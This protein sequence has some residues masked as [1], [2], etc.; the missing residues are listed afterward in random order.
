MAG[1]ARYSIGIL[2]LREHEQPDRDHQQHHQRDEVVRQGPGDRLTHGAR[3]GSHAAGVP[4]PRRVRAE[5]PVRRPGEEGDPDDVREGRQ[6][7]EPESQPSP[8]IRPTQAAGQEQR[9]QIGRTLGARQRGQPEEH[10]RAPGKASLDRKERRNDQHE[11]QRLRIGH[12]EHEREREQGQQSSRPDRAG[13]A[14]VRPSQSY[15]QHQRDGEQHEIEDDGDQANQVGPRQREYPNEHRIQGEEGVV[16]VAGVAECL[17][18]VAVSRDTDEPVPVPGRQRAQDRSR[19]TVRQ[20]RIDD[21]ESRFDDQRC[22]HDHHPRNDEC[23]DKRSVPAEYARLRV[24]RHA[25]SRQ[26]ATHTLDGMGR[27]DSRSN[28]TRRQGRKLA[29]DPMTFGWF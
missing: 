13:F 21:N 12:R 20:P 26:H 9:Q 5:V 27:T 14:E 8:A 25:R 2:S 16:V 29:L 3:A 7:T 18:V 4:T 11:R 28:V 10:P 17:D 1:I 15:Q 23:G 24:G 19:I 22:G 6:G